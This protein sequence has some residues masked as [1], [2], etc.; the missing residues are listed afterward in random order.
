MT[1]EHCVAV[2][3]KYRQS[4]PGISEVGVDQSSSPGA[5]QAQSFRRLRPK[6]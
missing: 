6:S 2:V 5:P 4:L 1:C 3:T